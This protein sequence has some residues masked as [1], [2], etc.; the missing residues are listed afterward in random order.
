MRIL[1]VGVQRCGGTRPRFPTNTIYA[2]RIILPK[3]PDTLKRVQDADL[4]VAKA[5]KEKRLYGKQVPD[6]VLLELKAAIKE[7]ES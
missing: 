1:G 5:R 6:K 7:Y 2:E 3:N 4:A